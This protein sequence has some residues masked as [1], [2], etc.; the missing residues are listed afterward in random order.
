MIYS[1]LKNKTSPNILKEAV[2][3]IGTKEIKGKD[4]NPIILGWA[5]EL[6]LEKIYKTDEIPWCGL[7]VALVVKRATFKPV[8]QPLWARAWV[9]FG[10]KQNSAMLGDVLI[11]SRGSG[12][13]VGL[14]V[15]E[16]NDCYHILGGNQGDEVKATRIRK[17]RLLGIRRCPWR[18]QQP[19][20]VKRISLTS[21][22]DI[23]INEN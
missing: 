7:F 17:N 3:L 9:G 2:K 5:K 12:G 1:W 4:H 10:T 19:D 6:G 23:S 18:I 11:F 21:T 16:D 14:Y 22:G 13:H 8:S 15:G 20:A